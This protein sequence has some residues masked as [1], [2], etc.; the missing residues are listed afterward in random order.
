MASNTKYLP[1]IPTAAAV[2]FCAYISASNIP[3]PNVYPIKKGD[4]IMAS[5]GT[6][7]ATNMNFEANDYQLIDENEKITEQIS[8]IHNFLSVLLEDSQDLDPKYSK[9]VDKYFWDLV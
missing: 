6:T 9:V 5:M 4:N 7:T 8:V 1:V 3:E 2:L